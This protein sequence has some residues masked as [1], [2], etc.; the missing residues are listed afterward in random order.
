MRGSNG[1]TSPVPEGKCW[2]PHCGTRQRLR[3]LARNWARFEKLCSRD[4]YAQATRER[5][6]DAVADDPAAEYAAQHLALAAQLAADES[7]QDVVN[8]LNQ[9]LNKFEENAA[10]APA[11]EGA[12]L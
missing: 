1:G 7:K 6:L 4:V 8:V 3:V 9:L 10:A 12:V 2:A 11:V 5:L